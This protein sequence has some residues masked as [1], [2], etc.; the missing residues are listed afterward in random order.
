MTNSAA[1]LAAE[2]GS[3]MSQRNRNG[4]APSMRAASTS[5]SGIATKTWRNNNVAVADAMSGNQRPVNV[6]ISP[7]SDITEKVGMMRTS[8]GN[9]SVMKINQNATCRQGNRKNAMANADS[10]EMMI[11]PIAIASAMPRDISNMRGT[12]PDRTRK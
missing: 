7:R 6:L 11:L 9:I 1:I 8:T 12:G 5:S 2:T 3:T 4:P 10:T